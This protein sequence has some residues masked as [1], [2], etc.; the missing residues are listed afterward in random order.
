MGGASGGVKGRVKTGEEDPEK[1][2]ATESSNN[3]LLECYRGLGL[4]ETL[5]PFGS[6]RR[7]NKAFWLSSFRHHTHDRV[8][9]LCTSPRRWDRCE[10]RAQ[11][12][13]GRETPGLTEIPIPP[14]MPPLH[15]A[16]LSPGQA[17]GL[18]MTS[19]DRQVLGRPLGTR[20]WPRRTTA[21]QV[22][23]SREQ[24]SSQHA[25]LQRR[26]TREQPIPE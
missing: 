25:S 2:V 26:R 4:V 15:S 20:S 9:V 24:L 18:Q 12:R 19:S 17:V 14:S 5:H 1:L 11:P 6:R 13:E 23:R 3:H 21:G 10:M 16:L 22:H 8:R 7:E